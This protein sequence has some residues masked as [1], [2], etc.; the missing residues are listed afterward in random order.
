[1]ETGDAMNQLVEQGKV[2]YL[3]V[4]NRTAQQ[5]GQEM[6][7]LATVAVNPSRRIVGVQNR[8]NLLQ[9]PGVSALDDPTVEDEAAF[10]KAIDQAGVGLSPYM[11]LA[12]GML[13]G[14]YRRGNLDTDGRLR[15]RSGEGWPDTYLTEPNLDVV[16]AMVAMAEEKA[17][18]VAQLTIAWLLARDEVCSVIAGV[19]R[20]AHLEDNAGA[21]AESL[22][23]EELER[24]DAL[25]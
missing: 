15:E 6:H 22:T 21:V 17:C 8:Y 4:S 10:L 5:L 13:T 16:E 12:V 25:D 3:A 2:R 24:L 11:P 19:T 20:M 23:A 18:T 14:R 9:R 1:M 7:A